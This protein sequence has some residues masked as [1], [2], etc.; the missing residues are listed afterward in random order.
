MSAPTPTYGDGVALHTDDPSL[1]WMQ[2]GASNRR[3]MRHAITVVER[4]LVGGTAGSDEEQSDVEAD[5]SVAETEQLPPSVNVRTCARPAEKD[6]DGFQESVR[7]GKPDLV[8]ERDREAGSSYDAS[9]PMGESANEFEWDETRSKGAADS[10]GRASEGDGE[11]EKNDVRPA[12]PRRPAKRGRSPSDG[13]RSASPRKKHH[14][15]V[16]GWSPTKAIAVRL[17]REPARRS[18]GEYESDPQ[19]KAIWFSMNLN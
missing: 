7:P 1:S 10:V 16:R 19:A 15:S 4:F 11:D 17:P 3:R 18:L 2:G 8:R 14:G 6:A 9:L 13:S 12:G 5:H